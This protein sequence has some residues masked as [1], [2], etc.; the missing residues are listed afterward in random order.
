MGKVLLDALIGAPLDSRGIRGTKLARKS[1]TGTPGDPAIRPPDDP[2]WWTSRECQIFLGGISKQRWGRLLTEHAIPTQTDD[3]GVSRYSCDAIIDLGD[4]LGLSEQTDSTA[5]ALNVLRETLEV[6][7]DYVKQ[8]Q[9]S[10]FQVLT[11]LRDENDSLR[12]LRAEEQASHLS[13]IRA[14]Q[15]ALDRSAERQQA[16]QQAEGAELRKSVILEYAIQ[17]VA[18]KLLDQLQKSGHANRVIELVKTLDADQ[19]AAIK[20][21]ISPEQA[22]SIDELRAIGTVETQLPAG[23][24]S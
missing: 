19:V 12:K 23:K 6:M 3:R 16:I 11:M 14:T 9:G 8:L 18:P 2:K 7:S 13:A 10:S 4:R 15:E 5:T 1:P 24:P 17:T 22:N 21:L 20:V